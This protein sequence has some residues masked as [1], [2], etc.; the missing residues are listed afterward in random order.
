MNLVPQLQNNTIII[1]EQITLIAALIDNQKRGLEKSENIEPE[2]AVHNPETVFTISRETILQHVTAYL[3]ANENPY[4]FPSATVTI[5]QEVSN[6]FPVLYLLT[7][8]TIHN[9][10]KLLLNESPLTMPL[11]LVDLQKQATSELKFEYRTGKKPGIRLRL[12]GVLVK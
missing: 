12:N 8:I 11:K 5:P 10:E 6:K 7:E 2:N 9:R 1:P 3:E 4:T